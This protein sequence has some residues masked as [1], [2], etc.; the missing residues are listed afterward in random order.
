MADRS[1]SSEVSRREAGEAKMIF[2]LTL[3]SVSLITLLITLAGYLFKKN[4]DDHKEL[5]RDVSVL[6]QGQARIEGKID[7]LVERKD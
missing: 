5:R 3:I 7:L 6:Q 4:E 2:A 1:G